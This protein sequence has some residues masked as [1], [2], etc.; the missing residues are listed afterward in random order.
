MQ[1]YKQINKND[2]FLIE[3]YKVIHTLYISYLISSLWIYLEPVERTKGFIFL[4]NFFFNC[5]YFLWWSLTLLPRL[6][7]SAIISA[8]CRPSPS[9]FK[10]FSCLSFPNSWDYRHTPP[11]PANFCTFSRDGFHIVGPGGL[12][13]LTSWS[14]CLDLPKWWYYRREPL[15]LAFISV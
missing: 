11:H 7:Y 2:L 13:L 14:T 1:F 3:V 12:E 5:F 10:W 8:Y 4:K 9:G 6:E 15:H